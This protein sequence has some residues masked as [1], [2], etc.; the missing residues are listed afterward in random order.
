[1]DLL[2]RA[3]AAQLNSTKTRRE[4]LGISDNSPDRDAVRTVEGSEPR[5]RRDEAMVRDHHPTQVV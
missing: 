2:L 4:P 3:S 5:H 1:L